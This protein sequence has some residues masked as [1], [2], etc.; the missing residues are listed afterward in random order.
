VKMEIGFPGGA[1]VK[2]RFRGYELLTDQTRNNGGE[3]SAAQP[4]DLF[5]ASL[6]TCAGLYALRFCQQ[7]EIDT[8]GL[9]LTLEPARDPT[10]RRLST[11]T[12]NLRLPADFPEKYE[13]AIVR[14]IDQCA[15]KRAILDP[16]AIETILTPGES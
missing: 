2:A 15:V 7:R 6:G 16:P 11:I 9:G 12:L 8:S 4:F 14:A 3:E 13:Q 5:L 1:R 10:G